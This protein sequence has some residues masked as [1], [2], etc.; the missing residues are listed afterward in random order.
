MV[1]QAILT[2]GHPACLLLP[3]LVCVES[4]SHPLTLCA[5]PPQT[6]A[7][8]PRGGGDKSAATTGTIQLPL[9]NV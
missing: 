7:A 5:L 3:C 6:L 8:L 4:C 9:F 1:G 2:A